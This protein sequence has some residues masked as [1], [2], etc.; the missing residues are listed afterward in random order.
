MLY[1]SNS[2][3]IWQSF[4]HPTETWLLEQKL[5]SGQRLIASASTTNWTAGPF[6]LLLS[7]SDLYAFIEAT[8]PQIYDQVF[9]G[10]NRS[11]PFKNGRFDLIQDKSNSAMVVYVSDENMLQINIIL[12][13]QPC[14]R[15][16]GMINECSLLTAVILESCVRTV[17]DLNHTEGSCRDKKYKVCNLEFLLNLFVSIPYKRGSKNVPDMRLSV[18]LMVAGKRSRR[19]EESI[20]EHPSSV[21]LLHASA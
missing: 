8:P 15:C 6:Y 13:P 18:Q 3:I 19:W 14:G 11:A 5:S 4:D 12:Q 21:S 20:T 1:D 17:E 16:Y 2:S 10:R 9:H 7:N